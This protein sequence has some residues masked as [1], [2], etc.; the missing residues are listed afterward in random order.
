MF[1]VFANHAPDASPSS[2]RRGDL[3]LASWSR[4]G[5]SYLVIG[6]RAED[7]ALA[8]AQKLEKRV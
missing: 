8:L 4:G 7:R 1:C 3:S 6:A 2:E 5:R